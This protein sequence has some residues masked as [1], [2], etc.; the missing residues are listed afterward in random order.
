[1]QLN[2]VVLGHRVPLL[3]KWPGVITPGTLYNDMISHLD[4]L[5]TL[6]AAAGNNTV[7]AD[8]AEGTEVN[9]KDFRV[10]LDGFNYLPYFKGEESNVPR[11]SYL[12]FGQAGD[13]NAIRWNDF[14]ISFAQTDGNIM[15]GTRTVTNWPLITNLKEDPYETAPYESLMYARW[16][17]DLM[18]VGAPVR[19]QLEQFMVTL[20]AYPFQQG[21][22]M[23]PA[24]FNYNTYK[25]MQLGKQLEN[26]KP[27]FDKL[28]TLQNLTNWSSSAE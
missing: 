19:Q 28:K 11:E 6:A 5:P 9:G 10:H 8:L 13:L 2:S 3:V 23:N 4:W 14:K 21:Q 16:A 7:K 1:M 12:Y 18:W 15:L 27:L 25:A 22:S 26:A 17:A 20:P 24:G